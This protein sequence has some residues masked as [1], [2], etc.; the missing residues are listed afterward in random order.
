MFNSLVS[1]EAVEGAAVLDLFAGT[2]GLGIEA[3]SRGAS[4]VTFVESVAE[5]ADVVRANLA[6][7]GLGERAD[8]VVG[9][10]QRY[11]DSTPR[12]FDLALL[13]PPYE[14]EEWPALLTGLPAALGVIESDRLPSMP[15]G[16]AV[17]RQKRYGG[18]VVATIRR[19]GP[20]PGA[21]T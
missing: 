5:I 4:R 21:T 19:T 14:F 13:D 10:A 7:T 8:V 18:T 2:G 11:I 12:S 6:T 15:D 3:L 1:L 17:L 9:D 20:T 16:W